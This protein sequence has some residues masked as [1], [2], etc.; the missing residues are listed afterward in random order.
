[1]ASATTVTMIERMYWE[2]GY[3]ELEIVDRLRVDPK[4]VA[5]IARK[6]TVVTRT[7]DEDLNEYRTVY[8]TRTRQTPL[9]T[10]G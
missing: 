2:H 6:D 5:A 7:W 3:T 9:R 1:M 4:L 10:E 8:T